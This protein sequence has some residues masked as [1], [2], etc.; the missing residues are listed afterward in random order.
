MPT[1]PPSNGPDAN[2]NPPDGASVDPEVVEIEADSIHPPPAPGMRL[3]TAKDS[4][5]QPLAITAQLPVPLWPP[6]TVAD[7][8]VRKIITVG[9][10]EPIGALE[11]CMQRFKFRHLPVVD[12]ARKLTGL[13]SRTDLLHAELGRKPDGT[14]AEKVD[15][16]TAAATIMRRKVV[17]AQLDTP[18]ATAAAVMLDNQLACLPVVLEDHTLVGI[19]TE[20]DFVRCTRNLLNGTP[21][22]N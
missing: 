6:R 16:S 12:A 20:A 7:L 9:E 17:V 11:D 14:T 1:T 3:K 2:E 19:I 15:A 8:M 5:T 21:D 13:I 22:A 18:L 10:D 4:T